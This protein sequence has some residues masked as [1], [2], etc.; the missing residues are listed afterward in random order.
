[1]N[2]LSGTVLVVAHVSAPLVILRSTPVL[3]YELNSLSGAV[4]V[5]AHFR[6]PLV[7]LSGAKNPFCF[8]YDEMLHLRLSMTYYAV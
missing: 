4:L 1:L 8:R 3:H 2:S 5:V 7:I 6:A